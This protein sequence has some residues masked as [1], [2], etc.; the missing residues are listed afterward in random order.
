MFENNV[1]PRGGGVCVHD[2]TAANG[3]TANSPSSPN[4][5]VVF[6]G[7]SAAHP[8]IDQRSPAMTWSACS[9]S[10]AWTTR[11]RRCTSWSPSRRDVGTPRTVT[12]SDRRRAP[13][14]RLGRSRTGS[15]TGVAT[16]VPGVRRGRL[17]PSPMTLDV[18]PM[19]PPDQSFL[20][21]LRGMSF[22]PAPWCPW[23]PRARRRD[24]VEFLR[25]SVIRIRR[26]RLRV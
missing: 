8:W 19:A 9:A 7:N 23:V 16:G 22:D 4:E 11:R 25:I 2:A 3:L 6:R 26:L 24:R 18:A 20:D 1:A 10:N 21:R 14:R 12:R 15:R 13:R 5:L 17:L